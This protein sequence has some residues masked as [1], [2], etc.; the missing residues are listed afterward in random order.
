MKKLLFIYT[1]SYESAYRMWAVDE[2]RKVCCF[3]GNITHNKRIMFNGNVH[4]TAIQELGSWYPDKKTEN[5]MVEVDSFEQ[6]IE[7]VISAV[8]ELFL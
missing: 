4:W 2:S 3:W 6:T 7:S 1:G 5:I 8:P